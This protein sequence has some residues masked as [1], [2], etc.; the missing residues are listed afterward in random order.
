MNNLIYKYLKTFLCEL[1]F[2]VATI[3]NRLLSTIFVCAIFFGTAGIYLKQWL[4]S[5]ALNINN[6]TYIL[7]YNKCPRLKWYE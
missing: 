6:T 4:Y 1:D 3:K 7:H 5:K 2:I